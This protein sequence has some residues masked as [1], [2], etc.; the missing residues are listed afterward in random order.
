MVL[1]VLAGRQ[2]GFHLSPIFTRPANP[3]KSVFGGP[4]FFLF[5]K[6]DLD[7]ELLLFL[8]DSGPMSE[9]S[10]STRELTT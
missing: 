10:C 9:P 4:T 3:P 5:G 7:P 2:I 6:L 1:D 8:F